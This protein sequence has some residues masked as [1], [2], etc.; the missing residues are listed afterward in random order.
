MKTSFGYVSLDDLS[1]DLERVS[2]DI[3]GALG[4]P[5]LPP[6]AQQI[7]PHLWLW[8]DVEG[9]L[10][11]LKKL[12]LAGNDH[13]GLERR[14][15]RL[16]NP[17]TPGVKTVTQT[18]SASVQEILPGEVAVSHRHT[19]SAIRFFLRGS[20]TYTTVEGDKCWMEPGDLIVT[21][22][23]AWHDY[24]NE[25]REPGIWLDALDFPLVQYMDAC[26]YVSRVD[27][28]VGYDT[29]ERTPPP[30]GAGLSESRYA[31]VGLR[32]AWEPREKGRRASLI[33]YRWRA[34]EAALQSLA[35]LDASPF[36]DVMM[37]YVNPATGE[38]VCQTITCCIQMLRPGV[39]TAA[40]R[41]SSSGVYYAFRGRGS[42]IIAGRRYDWNEGDLF[43]IPSWLWHE[44]LNQGPEPALLFSVHDAPAFKAL[45]IYREEPL[46]EG[47]QRVVNA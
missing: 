47:R 19:A 21:P 46:P 7:Q 8:S 10:E 2:V 33:H 25:G 44:H 17:G 23:W 11:K 13:E 12:E 35:R 38:S 24:G 27:E 37:E 45:G 42:T 1:A 5:L 34:T 6:I 15:V 40:H 18:M 41:Q 43:V 3:P 31:T 16:A 20:G 32:P 29:A 28:T 36:D 26:G 39:H 9:L 30:R 14:M 4:R 22:A